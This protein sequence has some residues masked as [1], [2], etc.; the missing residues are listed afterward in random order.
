MIHEKY[1][2]MIK[3]FDFISIDASLA[4]DVQQQ[5]VREIVKE[6][7]DLRLLSIGQGAPMKFYGKGIPNV[8][9]D[10]LTGKLIVIE[11]RGRQ[12][13]LHADTAFDR[14]S[15]RPRLRHGQRRSE[16]IELVC[17][18]LEQ[19]MR[20]MSQPGHALSFYATDFMDQLENNIIPACSAPDSSCWLIVTST[21]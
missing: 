20:A 5:T 19:A 10:D 1:S 6:K 17:A 3:E 8:N 11:G 9:A 14:F 21:L 15:R 2:R 13:P 12:R 16:A 18:E 4:V 7:V